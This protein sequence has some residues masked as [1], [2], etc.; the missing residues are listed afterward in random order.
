MNAIE[1]CPGVI[2]T[3]ESYRVYCTLVQGAFLSVLADTGLGKTNLRQYAEA[4]FPSPYIVVN[5]HG[6]ADHVGGN[7]FFDCAYLSEADRPLAGPDAG[8]LISLVPGAVFDLGDDT[9]RIVS[10]AGHTYGS[11][12]ILLERRR[13]LIA[14]DALSP[15]LLLLG[16]EACSPGILKHTLETALELPFDFYL[17]SHAPAPF[18][19]T[20]LET[21]LKHLDVLDPA[22]ITQT[23]SAGPKAWISRFSENSLRSEFVIG[24]ELFGK[25]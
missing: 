8:R 13:L 5:T 3:E 17:T 2:H 18:D 24:E 6:H 12:G 22:R 4:K 19:K 1:I 14:G 10:L 9:A 15:R 20:Q 21:H 7:R 25:L 16:K 11:C 23:R